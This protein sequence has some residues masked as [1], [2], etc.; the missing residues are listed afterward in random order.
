MFTLLDAAM[1]VPILLTSKLFPTSTCVHY[2]TAIFRKPLAN[3]CEWVFFCR[4]SQTI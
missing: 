1:L 2:R 3:G 4:P